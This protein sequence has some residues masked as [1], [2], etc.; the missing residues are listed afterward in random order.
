MTFATKEDG[1]CYSRSIFFHINN[2]LLLIVAKLQK[3]IEYQRLLRFIMQIVG[4]SL[5]RMWE[6]HYADCGD[7]IKQN[8]GISLSRLCFSGI[9]PQCMSL[10]K[11]KG[12]EDCR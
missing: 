5:C 10:K 4:I 6:F 8:V 11:S 7:F 3:V 1:S 2:V 12:N 9:K